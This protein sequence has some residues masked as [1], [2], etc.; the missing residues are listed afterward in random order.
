MATESLVQYRVL[1][2]PGVEVTWTPY[3]PLDLSSES[4]DP[5]GFG[6]GYLALA[7]H[8]LPSFTT[9]T[10]VPRYTS[11]LCAGVQLASAECPRGSLASPSK[12][13]LARLEM[14]KSFE[15]AWAVA[16]GL[17][18][19]NS[20]G[21][22]AVLGL[23]GIRSVQRLLAEKSAAQKIRTG[24]FNLLSNQQRYGGIGAYSTFL[25]KCH[26]A[27][28]QDLTLKPL[29]AELAQKFPGPGVGLKVWDE[30]ADLPKDALL[31]W[32]CRANT[33]GFSPEEAKV[34]RDALSGE[35]E[36]NYNDRLRWT[37]LRML[38]ALAQA[39]EP[40]L[41][42]SWL[43][44]F[45]EN[46]FDRLNAPTDCKAQIRA[47]LP[48]LVNYE[49]FYQ[50]ALYVFNLVRTAATEQMDITLE[51]IAKQS[52]TV[53]GVATVR[54]RA[55]ILVSELHRSRLKTDTTRQINDVLTDSGVIGLATAIQGSHGVELLRLLLT[56]H[57]EVQA[58][59]FDG[60]LPKAA[61][62]LEHK[63]QVRLTAQRHRLPMRACP[64]SWSDV[65]WHPYRTDAAYQFIRSCRIHK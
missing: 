33:A 48:V 34:L 5:L 54:R 3:D 42:R 64:Q 56:R 32:G 37:S 60:A 31:D 61:W 20:A 52:A 35:Q 30:D 58:G 26:L 12:E 18:A 7:D 21:E 63:G 8:L 55:R 38:S 15:R 28:M 14:I 22:N 53:K 11:M 51:D 19:Q 57:K 25:E 40:Q 27:N 50:S 2:W 1:T 41:F 45:R 65:D 6:R 44:A 16:C 49:K 9:I 43:S 46:T 47:T 29:G 13:R 24:S 36:G 17:A 59:K 10:V 39:A 62:L 4:I 23:R